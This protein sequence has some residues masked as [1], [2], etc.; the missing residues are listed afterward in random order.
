MF[1]ANDGT[2]GNEI[3]KSNGSAAGT[4]L[5]KD[6]AAGVVGSNPKELT[7]VGG[8]LFFSASNGISGNELWKSNASSTGTTLV[9]DIYV[10]ASGSNPRNLTNVNGTMFFSAFDGVNG[11]ELWKRKASGGATTM[12]ADIDP[13]LRSSSPTFL[14]AAGVNLFFAATTIANGNELWTMRN[15][16]SADLPPA[17]MSAN[18]PGK[19]QG[20]APWSLRALQ[21]LPDQSR[22]TNGL[23]S[24]DRVFSG[25]LGDLAFSQPLANVPLQTARLQPV[26]VIQQRWHATVGEALLPELDHFFTHEM[27]NGVA[28]FHLDNF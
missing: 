12:A 10:G 19:E 3:W 23:I 20:R 18:G 13:G 25:P 27:Q 17:M 1:V 6:I 2:S 26:R 22:S 7:N 16:V 28:D 5:I 8:T 4:T 9:R 24:R 21:P 11:R 15:P 14:A